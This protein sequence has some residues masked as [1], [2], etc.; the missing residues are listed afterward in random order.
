MTI[1]LRKSYSFDLQRVS[2]LNGLSICVRVS[3]LFGTEGG[4]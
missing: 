3:F 4:I 2:T 1:C